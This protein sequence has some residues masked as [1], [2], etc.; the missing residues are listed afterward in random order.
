MEVKGL[1]TLYPVVEVRD[2]CGEWQP[3]EEQK[4]MEP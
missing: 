2:W 3:N 1:S 4:K